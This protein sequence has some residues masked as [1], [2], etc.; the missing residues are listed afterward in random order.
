MIPTVSQVIEIA[1]IL[2][3]MCN[4]STELVMVFSQIL[5]GSNSTRNVI[6]ATESVTD[7]IQNTAD[8]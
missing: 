6:N 1:L 7:S 8:S 3:S 2:A 5:N 4:D